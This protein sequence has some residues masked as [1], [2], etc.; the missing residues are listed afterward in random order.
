MPEYDARLVLHTGT[1]TAWDCECPGLCRAK[2]EEEH[3]PGTRFAFPYRGVYVHSVGTK[4]HVADANQLV[5]TNADEPYRVSHPVA[6]GDATLTLGIDPA[7]LLEV[8]PL[9]YRRS[10]GQAALNRSVLRIDARTQVLAAQLRQ[11][12]VRGSI[13]QL[14]G[15]TLVLHVIRHALTGDV[16]ASPTRGSR[17]PEKMADQVKMLLSADPWRRWTLTAI[18][19]EV[20]VT[21]VY[22]TD[23]F[24]RVEGIPL[25]RYHLQLRLAFA[26]TVLAHCD[27][28]MALAIDLGFHSHSHF[29]AAF[30]KAFGHTPSE[31]Q[32]SVVGRSA[33]HR[34]GEEVNAKILDSARAYVS[35][36][37][38]EGCHK[39]PDV[40]AIAARSVA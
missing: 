33:Q 12:L 23:A 5:I 16:S 19:E 13:D 17:R 9:E 29:S 27:D 26:L 22:L 39:P 2:A 20:S 34:Y 11:R 35:R 21:P 3:A 38:C 40:R 37:V 6:G 4:D 32:R 10:R 30:K 15:E 1:V 18:A 25:Y 24:R 31:F 28:L 14:E 7:T 36:S 8:T